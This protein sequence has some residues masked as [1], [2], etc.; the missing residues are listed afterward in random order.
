MV[1]DPVAQAVCDRLRD[2]GNP[3]VEQLGVQRA[4]EGL[5]NWNLLAPAGPG[6]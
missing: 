5:R 1:L 3:T 4:R 2:L 6:D